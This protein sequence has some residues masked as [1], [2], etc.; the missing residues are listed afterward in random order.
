MGLQ[1]FRVPKDVVFGEGSLAYL[2]ELEGKR[3]MLVTGGS[4]MKKFG[5]LDEA[6]ALLEKGGMAVEIIDGVEPNPSVDTVVSGA[7]AM[8]RFEPDWIVAIGGGSALDA[9]KVMWAFY[10]HP[11][12]KFEDII[13]PGSMPKLR[14]KARFVA[15]PS[16]SGTASEITAF[17]VI[18]DTK[19]HIKYPIVSYEMTPDVAILD[20]KLPAKMPAH[21]TANTGMDVLAHALEAYV[22]TNATSYTDP[23]ALKAID[24]VFNKLPQAYSNPDDMKARDDMHNASTLAGMAFTNASLGLVHSLAHKIGGEFGVTHGLANAI[25][26]P[27]IVQYNKMGTDRYADVERALGVED[28][29]EAIKDLNRNLGIPLSFKDVDEVEISEAKFN[30]V[31]D[32]MSKNAFEDPCTLTNPKDSCPE[33][34]A[35]IYKAAFYG[36]DIKR[37]YFE[38][39]TLVTSK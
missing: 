10:E 7:E 22:S 38:G 6:K 4:S 21:I 39:K 9:A 12:L 20:P 17:S 16:T 34:V 31:L 33:D 11:E 15:I 29:S 24:L 1:W 32:R 25:L 3:A 18:T 27:Y 26:M 19:N 23:I 35:M 5:F 28:L 13:E 8:R 37:E 36:E 2:A 14:N 30:E